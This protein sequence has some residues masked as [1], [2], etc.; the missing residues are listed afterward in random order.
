[1]ALLK[2]LAFGGFENRISLA[3]QNMLK[4]IMRLDA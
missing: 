3:L 4:K 1:M 2:S